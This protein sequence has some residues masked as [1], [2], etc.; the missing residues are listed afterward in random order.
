MATKFSSVYKQEL[1]NKGALSSMGSAV[2][3]SAR[4]RMDVRNIFF[5]GKG[6]LSA[7]G[8]KIFGRGYSALSSGATG[9]VSNAQVAAQSAATNDLISSNER[10]EALLRV[11]AKNTFNMN[12]MA[13]DMNITRQNIATL[14]RF[15]AGKAAQS[16]DAMWYDVKTRNQAIDSLGRKSESKNKTPE[17][18]GGSSFFGSIFGGLGSV[19]GAMGSVLGSVLGSVGSG[20]LAV[21][22]TV[23]RLSPL[24]AIVGIAA[25]AYVIKELSKIDWGLGTL[26]DFE[27]IKK[28]LYDA[29][30]YDPKSE[31]TFVEQMAAKLDQV[32]GTTKFTE[33]TKWIEKNFGPIA[34]DI[35]RAI[36]EVTDTSMVY[37]KAAFMTLSNSFAN[38][39]ALMG[40]YFK[41]FLT[42]HQGKLF[43]AMGAVIGVRFGLPGAAVGAA[44][45]GAIGTAASDTP[46]A[47]LP[48]SVEKMKKD[49]QDFQKQRSVSLSQALERRAKGGL[50]E[51]NLSAN[52]RTLLGM[53]D[54]LVIEEGRLKEFEAAQGRGIFQ[55]V[56]GDFEKYIREGMQNLPGGRPGGGYV[57][58]F[59]PPPDYEGGSNFGTTGKV[60]TAPSQ[61]TKGQKIA[62]FT[63]TSPYGQRADPFTGK[64][65][66]DHKGVD[67]AMDVGTPLRA[68]ADGKIVAVGFNRVAGNFITL[69]DA[70]GTEYSYSH[71][72]SQDVKVGQE[73]KRGDLIGKSGNTGRSTKPHLHFGV[74]EKGQYRA[75]LEVEVENALTQA[76]KVSQ[77][78]IDNLDQMR[79]LMFPGG[80]GETVVNNVNNNYSGGRGESQA[81]VSVVNYDVIEYFAARST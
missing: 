33:S 79:A 30:G 35:G 67:L 5:G 32:F 61:I 49:I 37:M 43:A 80:G 31:K 10:Q 13:R 18:T 65:V 20:I 58:R 74:K 48:D 78:S 41:D 64:G 55:N 38:L 26:I 44:V 34:D 12:M 50:F 25:T 42:Q 53:H 29:I 76:Q 47:Q 73:V 6:V 27:P 36:A 2:L 39:G 7:T 28:R 69:R 9:A 3:K 60:G 16:Q 19:L 22:G 23:L 59:T 46:L 45:A 52:E 77:L 1:K 8:Q 71:L 63:V 75:P 14:T 24:L 72:S 4:E 66:E 81:L 40:F 21:F 70:N 17:K 57:P 62:G 68:V 15:A 51:Q 54:R 56:P 11:V